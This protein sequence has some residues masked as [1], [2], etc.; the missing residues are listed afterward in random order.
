MLALLL[1]Q[2]PGSTT[3]GIGVSFRSCH[4]PTVF[5]SMRKC[6]NKLLKW[7][8][9]LKLVWL[10]P[11]GWFPLPAYCHSCPFINSGISALGLFHTSDWLHNNSQRT[12]HPSSK[13]I[14]TSCTRLFYHLWM[15]ACYHPC[16]FQDAP[17]RVLQTSAG[18]LAA[19]TFW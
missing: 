6:F 9:G 3:T 11:V 16:V 12:Q 8:R 5:S 18:S 1:A 2:A 7:A 19:S 17:W 13:Q 4:V 15:K 14:L 10:W